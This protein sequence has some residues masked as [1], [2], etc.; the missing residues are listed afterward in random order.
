MSRNQPSFSEIG[1]LWQWPRTY[2]V[3]PASIK[4]FFIS[5]IAVTGILIGT[6]RQAEVSV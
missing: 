5:A 4:A 2:S 6:N 3:M 1:G